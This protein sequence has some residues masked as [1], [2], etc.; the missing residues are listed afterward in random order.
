MP[1]HNFCYN[2]GFL[3][4]WLTANPGIKRYDVLAK[5]GMSDYRTLQNWM[6]GLTMMPLTQ[7][8]RFCNIYNVPLTAFFYD[9]AA[10]DTSVFTPLT[11]NAMIE[12]AGGWPTSERKTGI[13][14]CDPRCDTHFKS[15]LPDYCHTENSVTADI[16]PH[17]DSS[18]PSDISLAERMRYLD[19]IEKMNDRIIELTR[20]NNQL[21][22][23]INHL[24]TPSYRS[25]AAEDDRH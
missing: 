15:N 17:E 7:M 23:S 10:T 20:E 6:A 25:F 21:Q 8:M 24:S 4:D 16:H 5:M 12:P 19:I 18:T 11:P 22:N 14:V 9:E 3:A 2:Y 13:K 1:N